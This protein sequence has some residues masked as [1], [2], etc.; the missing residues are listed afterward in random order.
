MKFLFTT[1]ISFGFTALAAFAGPVNKKCPVS[2]KDIDEDHVVKY[3]V[4]FCCEK[5]KAKFDADPISMAEK[6]ATAEADKC[7]ASGKAADKEQSSDLEI[8]TCC[9]KCET[10]VKDDPKTY[11]GK[12]KAE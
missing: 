3:A 7:P 1:I 11:I 10:K 5:C 12:L 8:A 2:G 9:S 6:I 4:S